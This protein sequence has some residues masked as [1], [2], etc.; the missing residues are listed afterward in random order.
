M[1]DDAV[2]LRLAPKDGCDRGGL[3]LHACAANGSESELAGCAFNTE[4]IKWLRLQFWISGVEASRKDQPEWRRCQ[5]RL[6]WLVFTVQRA[7]RC[8]RE[9][10]MNS[11]QKF[12]RRPS[13]PDDF[14]GLVI[15]AKADGISLFP[16]ISMRNTWKIWPKADHLWCDFVG[17]RKNGG[18]PLLTLDGVG[19]I[20]WTLNQN[21]KNDI[22]VFRFLG[23]AD[24][25]Q[26][27]ERPPTRFADV[28][29]ELLR[30]ADA[31]CVCPD[32]L[33]GG[34]NQPGL[35]FHPT[36]GDLVEVTAIEALVIVLL[37]VGPFSSIVM[38]ARCGLLLLGCSMVTIKSASKE[39][40]V[41]LYRR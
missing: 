29:G 35:R 24:L 21:G 15:E 31:E 41:S 6:Q 16:E 36:R 9:P 38:T 33:A 37:S 30:F 2:S 18:Q 7:R 12:S 3:L 20:L 26:S 11:L 32:N 39:S 22:F 28:T 23:T 8:V 25:V 27:G 13:Q 34:I 1:P 17:F 19:Q 5:K 14:V 40:A 10:E 4:Q